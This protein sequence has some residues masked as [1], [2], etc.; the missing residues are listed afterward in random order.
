MLHTNAR[1][2]GK[3]NTVKGLT[4]KG[5]IKELKTDLVLLIHLFLPDS[6]THV[7]GHPGIARTGL[8]SVLRYNRIVR[9][10]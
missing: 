9:M 4:Q 7:A 2:G 3:E 1:H 6:A 5:N 10:E 8:G